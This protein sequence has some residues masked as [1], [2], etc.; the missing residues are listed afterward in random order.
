MVDEHRRYYGAW[1]FDLDE[2]RQSVTIWQGE[3]DTFVRMSHAGR[4]ATAPSHAILRVVPPTGHL[5]PLV[6]ADEIV[7]D[8]AP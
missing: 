8:L 6:V 3:Q 7:E 1:G 5:L 4:L 2:V